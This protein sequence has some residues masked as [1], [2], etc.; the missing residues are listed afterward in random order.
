MVHD[1]NR[2]INQAIATCPP[3][4]Y[5]SFIYFITSTMGAGVPHKNSEEII[6]TNTRALGMMKAWKNRSVVMGVAC[7]SVQ[8]N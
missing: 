8:I 5:H 2:L 6:T 3:S 1:T 4:L 7:E